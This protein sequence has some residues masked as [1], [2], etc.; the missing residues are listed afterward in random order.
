MILPAE[1]RIVDKE[2]VKKRNYRNKTANHTYTSKQ[3]FEKLVDL[4]LLSNSKK[5]FYV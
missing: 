3:T 5:S 4:I 2:I 1:I